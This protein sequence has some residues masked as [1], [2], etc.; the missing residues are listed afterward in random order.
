MEN[1]TKSE[2]AAQLN[3]QLDAK[4]QELAQCVEYLHQAEK[5]VEERTRWAQTA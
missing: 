2:W 3:A 1:R 5:T 4:L